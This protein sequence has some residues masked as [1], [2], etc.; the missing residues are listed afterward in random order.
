[1]LM[2]DIPSARATTV[3]FIIFLLFPDVEIPKKA[4]PVRPNPKSCCANTPY[5][6]TS[7]IYAVLNA[8]CATNGIAIKE[9]SKF[10]AKKKGKRVYTMDRLEEKLQKHINLLI[11]RYPILEEIRD[12]IISAYFVLEATYS[13]DGKLLIAGNGG[14]AADAEHIAG[15]LMKRFKTP[16]PVNEEFAEKLKA[17][18]LERGEDFQTK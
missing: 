18:D 8:S 12:D 7:L 6:S 17:I 9:H 14:S 13:H 3:A 4:S 16:R 11:N 5:P 15:E 2:L 1:M 10:L